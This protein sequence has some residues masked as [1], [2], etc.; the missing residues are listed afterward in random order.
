MAS[1]RVERVI[2]T[3]R[4]S[5]K[6]GK[7][8]GAMALSMAMTSLSYYSGYYSAQATGSP[9]FFYNVYVFRVPPPNVNLAASPDGK[10]VY[11]LNTQTNDVT[12]INVADGNADEKIAIGGG[13]RRVQLAPGGRF[14]CAF[15]PGQV[16]LIDV[17]RK[18]KALEQKVA[19]GK[20]HNIEMD[21][22]NRRILALTT[23]SILVWDSDSGKLLATVVGFSRPTLVL[24]TN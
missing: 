13:A 15:S 17:A 9:F 18:T 12:V 2:T 19:Y 7:F 24:Q 20:V 14:V 5:V 10:T 6:F 23:N 4:G 3:G 1:N 11:A 16:T 8:M 21:D 22:S